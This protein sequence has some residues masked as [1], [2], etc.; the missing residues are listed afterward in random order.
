MI[1]AKITI[2]S[3]NPKLPPQIVD[4]FV[5]YE[6]APLAVT[7]FYK[8]G[9]ARW[10]ATDEWCISHIPTGRQVG[11]NEGHKWDTPQE[12]MVVLNKC[13]PDF[14][15]WFVA[16]GGIETDAATQACHLIFKAAVK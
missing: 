11:T 8:W 16:R 5:P 9:R 14:P 3:T 12:A 1:P 7:P 10:I 6:G 4:G 15:A 13:R 2:S